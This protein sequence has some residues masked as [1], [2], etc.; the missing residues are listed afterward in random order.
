MFEYGNIYARNDEIA[1]FKF[2]LFMFL[3]YLCMYDA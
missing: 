1:Q 2:D 3:P